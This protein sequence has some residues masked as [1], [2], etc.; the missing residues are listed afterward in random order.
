M[1]YDLKEHDREDTVIVNLCVVRLMIGTVVSDFGEG[2]NGP[3]K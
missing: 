2:L 1:L 3:Q